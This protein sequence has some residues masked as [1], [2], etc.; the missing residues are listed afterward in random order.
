MFKPNTTKIVIFNGFWT[1]D[2]VKNNRHCLFVYGD[3]D[4]KIGRGGQAIIRDE[5]N[6]IGIPTKKYPA[7]QVYS[8]YTDTELET[9]KFKIDSA[10][11]NIIQN[12]KGYQYIVLP[13]ER[14][15]SGLSE[16]PT[17]APMTYK[18]L[19]MRVSQLEKYYN[20]EDV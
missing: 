9:N 14:F 17:R 10:I 3:N 2:D 5:K 1:V 15:G 18:Y 7:R 11:L 6:T 8:Y 20:L 12:S 16:L 13:S 4:A 19:Q